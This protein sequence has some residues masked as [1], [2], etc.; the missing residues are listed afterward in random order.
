MLTERLTREILVNSVFNQ[1][2]KMAHS[3]QVK[4]NDYATV[5]EIEGAWQPDD[6]AALLD[7]MDF[8]DRTGLGD[9]ELR[10][11]CL[12]FLQDQKPEDAAFIVLQ[13]IIDDDLR[14]G[15]LRNMA[16]EMGEEKLWEEY[17]EPAFHAR[18]FTVGSL[19][20]AASPAA[21]PKTDAV[22]I[23][24]KITALDGGSKDLS[25]PAPD[26]TFLI[27]LLAGGMDDH[28]VLHRLYGEELKGT[29]F[30]NAA[31]ILWS[32]RSEATADGS[33]LIEIISSGYW[34]DA[35]ERTESYEVKAYA[36]LSTDE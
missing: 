32:T 17:V 13:Y 2:L 7:T 18:L 15:Q 19:L 11:M 16:N 23:E 9:I 30:P 36:D 29:S 14:E 24:L 20:Y 6:Y 8:G 10:E 5:Q 27:R 35:L 31:E 3:F 25:P 4:V 22:R 33:F 12:M 28:A 34:L 1:V 26:P 21:F